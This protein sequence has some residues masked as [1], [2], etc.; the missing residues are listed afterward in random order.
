MEQAQVFQLIEEVRKR[1]QFWNKN[2]TGFELKRQKG[3]EWNRVAIILNI[4]KTVI[5][6]KWKSIREI[7][8]REYKKVQNS[9]K[10]GAGAADAYVS[11]DPY[12]ESLLFLKNTLEPAETESNLACLN[13]EEKEQSNEKENI[14][15]DPIDQLYNDHK[16]SSIQKKRHLIRATQKN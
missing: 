8:K 2:Q 10:S 12:Y 13:D 7:F 1:P 16:V 3:E 15:I 14:L 11:A 5:Q 4:D 6:K 9:T